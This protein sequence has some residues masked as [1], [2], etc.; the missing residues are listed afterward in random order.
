M[1]HRQMLAVLSD[2]GRRCPL[3]DEELTGH[4]PGHLPTCPERENATED[5]A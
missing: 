2:E 1:N 3:C 5:D 4:L